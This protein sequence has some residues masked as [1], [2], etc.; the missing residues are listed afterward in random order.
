MAKF[1]RKKSKGGGGGGGGGIASGSQWSGFIAIVFGAVALL[2]DLIAYGIVLSN[3]DTAYTTA[4]GYTWMTGLT[5]IMGIWPMVLFLVFMAAGI[6]AIG[7]G[8]YMNWR[9]AAHGSWTDIFIVFIMGAV[10]V[11]ITVIMF[12][13]INT[14]M[15]TLAVAINATTNVASFVG[16]VSI[17][18]IWPMVIFLVMIGASVAQMGAAGY[19][20]YKQLAGKTT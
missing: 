17:V 12:G 19:G 4:S 13:I 1:R 20:G 3:Y 8:A 2:V 10:S 9:R 7:V 6:G 16:L 5:S 14:Q 15:N 11:V 18:G